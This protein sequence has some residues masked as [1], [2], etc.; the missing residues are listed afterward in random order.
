MVVLVTS[1][2]AH[3]CTMEPNSLYDFQ[4]PT[5]IVE[6]LITLCRCM[7]NKKKSKKF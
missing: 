7:C 3:A 2:L 5:V 1:K 6:I 4:K